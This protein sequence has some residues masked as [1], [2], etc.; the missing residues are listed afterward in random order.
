[1][2]GTMP[3]GTFGGYGKGMPPSGAMIPQSMGKGMPMTMPMSKGMPMTMPMSKGQGKGMM[4]SKGMHMGKNGY[5]EAEQ[6]ES[7]WEKMFG[8]EKEPEFVNYSQGPVPAPTYLSQSQ[9]QSQA[10]MMPIPWQKREAEA[11]RETKP[12]PAYDTSTPEQLQA[13]AR[14]RNKEIESLQKEV[15]ALTDLESHET[16]LA[17][18][19]QKFGGL[20]QGSDLKIKAPLLA[21]ISQVVR[22]S[23]LLD[24]DLQIQ[25]VKENADEM[26]PEGELS[27]WEYM[28]SQNLV[29]GRGCMALDR[30]Y[31]EKKKFKEQLEADM[32]PVVH[33]VHYAGHIPRPLRMWRASLS[34]SL[35]STRNK[36]FILLHTGEGSG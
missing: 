30:G 19:E 26:H 15:A 28:H 20:C 17:Q 24:H 36:L 7:M 32:H 18:L 10:Q 8:A 9:S 13:M 6:E 3:S 1:M 12:N 33:R 27:P 22:E 34:R 29:L 23:H 31:A 11:P 25:T 21:K 5:L 16:R 2:V 4:M 35:A 14:S